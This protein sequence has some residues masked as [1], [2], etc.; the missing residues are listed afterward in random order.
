MDNPCEVSDGVPSAC[1]EKSRSVACSSKKEAGGLKAVKALGDWRPGMA[2]PLEAGRE[3]RYGLPTGS[4][5]G[6]QGCDAGMGKAVQG[7]CQLSACGSL[8]GEQFSSF[9]T[10]GLRKVS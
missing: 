10:W 9:L 1:V 6:G 5:T 3:A 4:R 7:G 8:K 2:C